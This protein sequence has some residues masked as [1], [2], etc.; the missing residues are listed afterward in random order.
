[1]AYGHDC[2]VRVRVMITIID[3]PSPH[4]TGFVQPGPIFPDDEGEDDD[5][6]DLGLYGEDED[7]E[8]GSRLWYLDGD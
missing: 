6:G 5:M 8:V 3:S 2:D 7:E 4:H 1:M